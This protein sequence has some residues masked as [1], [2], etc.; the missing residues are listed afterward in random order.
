MT[1][2]KAPHY[3]IEAQVPDTPPDYRWDN[4]VEEEMMFHQPRIAHRIAAMSHRAACAFSLGAIE[5]TLWRLHRELPDEG[6]FDL[7]DAAWAALADWSY[8]KTFKLPNWEEDYERPIGGPLAESFFCLQESFGNARDGKPFI[9][10]PVS[11]SEIALRICGREEAFKTWRRG[12][13]ERLI[14]LCPMDLSAPL[15]RPLP[16]DVVDPAYT[17]SIE[18]DDARI[19]AYLA[20]LDWDGNAHLGRPAS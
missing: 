19:K 15:G 6:A 11:L 9:H 16:R 17:P 14:E 3:I 1:K 2:H 4:E 18:S 12:I 7:V 20:G 8:L 13:I 5:W 10:M